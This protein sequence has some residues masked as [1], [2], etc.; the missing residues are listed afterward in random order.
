MD[1]GPFRAIKSD[2]IL[3]PSLPRLGIRISSDFIYLGKLHYISANTYHVELFIF[4][5]PNSLG[6][7]TRMLLVQFAGFLGNK[8]GVYLYP[9]RSAIDFQGEAYLYEEQSIELEDFLKRYPNTEMAHAADYIRQ[10]SYTLAG[11]M[12]HVRFSR[13]VSGDRRNEFAITYLDNT[14]E[15]PPGAVEVSNEKQSSLL[16]RALSSF[17]V[18]PYDSAAGNQ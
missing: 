9:E 4:L 18:V 3:S 5:S 10:R 16:D 7:V 13:L 12:R 11:D 15:E 14:P 2:T 6:H 1:F 8:A 17:S